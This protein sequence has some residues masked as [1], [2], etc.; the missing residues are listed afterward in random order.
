MI[1]RKT[2][3]GIMVLTM[4][5]A[6]SYWASR[7]QKDPEPRPTRGLDTQLDYAL[8][9]FEYQF[10]DLKGLPTI[11]L[12][13]PELSNNAASG[14]SRISHPVFNI[15][16]RGISWEIIAESA[17]VTADRERVVLNG[18]VWIRRPASFLGEL[19]N[20]RTSE[21]TIDLNERIASSVHA[22]RMTQGNDIMEAVG[23]RVNMVNNR[24]QL[25][26]QVKITYA[27][28]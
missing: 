24:F 18:S 3:M 28:N 19:L 2:Q 25:L 27:V 4:L 6:V 13:A 11:R 22:V 12:T 21:L 15:V 5:V 26:D 9:D 16:E 1:L 14:I 20:L 7:G 10:Y 17:T 8:Q 23:F